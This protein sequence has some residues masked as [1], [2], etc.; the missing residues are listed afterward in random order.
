MTIRYRT[1]IASIYA[2]MFLVAMC[3]VFA[4]RTPAERTPLVHHIQK[5]NP[6]LA[7]PNMVDRLDFFDT[8]EAF[9][10]AMMQHVAISTTQPASVILSDQRPKSFP[11]SGTWTSEIVETEF[12]FTELIPSWNATVPRDTG[13]FF[14]VKTR[15][16]SDGEWSPWLY[17]GQWGRTPATDPSDRVIEFDHGVVNVDNL[18]LDS[19]ATA[20]Q[21]RATLLSFDMNRDVVPQIRRITVSYS[22]AVDDPDERA[23]LAKSEPLDGDWARSLAVPFRA[24]GVEA[25]P[26]AGQ[27]CS[28]TSTSMVMS[29]FGVDRPTS[30]N[31]LAIYDEEHDMFGNWGRAV[32]RA[33]SLGLD[34]WLQRFRNWDQVKA[35]IAR[36]QP[37]VAG[38]KFKPGEFPSALY[39]ETAGHL[40]VIRGFTK[41]GDPIVNDPA[42]RNKGN[43]VVY[44]ADELG[45]AWFGCG[46]VGYVIRKP[47]NSPATMPAVVS[48]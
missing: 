28:P 42:D 31:A 8:P 30:E 10:R 40:I 6:L 37:V 4:F 1:L 46:G 24:Q 45:R 11:R 19:P 25:K 43:G 15:D 38:I 33:G 36:G 34:A 16:A 22:G 20:Y 7:R 9:D 47:Q 35:M 5:S 29:Y 3:A 13:V 41:S 26:L 39:K 27:I 21:I 48:K 17:I 32:Q 14:Q 23:Q 18:T 44:K 12:P 2:A